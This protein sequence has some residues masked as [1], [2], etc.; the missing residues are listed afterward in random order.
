MLKVNLLATA[1]TLTIMLLCLAPVTAGQQPGLGQAQM[2]ELAQEFAPRL[3]LHPDEI[4]KPVSPEYAISR[5]DLKN[6]NTG[7]ITPNPTASQ[8]SALTDPS[9][10]YYLDNRLGTISDDGIKEEFLDSY[11]NYAPTVYYRVTEIAYGSQT[12][13]AIQYFFYYAFN[14]GPMNTHEGDWEMVMVVCDTSLEPVFTAYSQHLGGERADWELVSRYGTHPNVYVALG[15]HANYYRPYQG[16]LGPASDSCSD[17]GWL[18]APEIYSLV[19]L[20]ITAPSMG[21][22]NFAG[23][24]GDY[25]RESSGMLGERGPVGP[26]YQG[27]RWNDPITW[28]EGVKEVTEESLSMNWALHYV[29]WMILGIMALAF[30]VTIFVIYRRKKKHGTL[31]PRLLPFLYVSGGNARSIAAVLVILALVVGVM[32]YF[33]PWYSIT[34]DI[35]AGEYSTPG[36]VEVLRTNGVD[37]MSFNRPEPGAGLVQVVSVPVPAGWLMLFG[38]FIFIFSSIGYIKTRKYGWKLLRRAISVMMPAVILIAQV[39]LIGY[40]VDGYVHDAPPEVMEIIDTVSA[41][42]L[43]GTTTGTIGEYGTVTLEWGIGPG[44]VMLLMSA[45]LLFI[46]AVMLIMDNKTFFRAGPPTNVAQ[47][48]G[49]Q[50]A[51]QAYQQPVQGQYQPYTPPVPGYG[52]PPP[53]AY[54]QPQSVQVFC[55]ACG[56]PYS[57]MHGTQPFQCTGCGSWV[58]PPPIQ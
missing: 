16:K 4:F 32:G 40:F 34:M 24:W 9:A 14:N 55:P 27:D 20:D 36:P 5:S 25:G 39:S 57:V 42:P 58:Y 48:Y 23:N 52:P 46:A 2:A 1:I 26:R 50:Q 15:S 3:Y 13:Y 54:G 53:G 30:L 37:G 35:E 11:D 31:G 19:N 8:L 22:L 49:Q 29:F 45:L 17:S 18:L 56:A 28:S 44:V 7:L 21:W 33:L 10:G 51:Y 12:V 38:L 41:N 47:P 6:I 43:A